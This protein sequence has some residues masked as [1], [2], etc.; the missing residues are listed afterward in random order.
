[1]AVKRIKI[2]FQKQANKAIYLFA[3]GVIE[4]GNFKY[5]GRY[6][7]IFKSYFVK[8]SDLVHDRQVVEYD[9]SEYKY[10]TAINMYDDYITS[11]FLESISSE[12][13]EKFA[14]ETEVVILVEEIIAEFKIAVTKK[15]K[16]IIKQ[17]DQNGKLNPPYA[18]MIL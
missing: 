2:G 17:S 16:R 8:I 18:W 12:Q 14:N 4:C 13:V 7:K 6:K 11:H 3:T 9:V 1:M 5:S 10:W 15:W